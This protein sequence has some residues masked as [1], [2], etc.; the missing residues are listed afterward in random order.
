MNKKQKVEIGTFQLRIRQR[1]VDALHEE[2]DDVE[3]QLNGNA[4]I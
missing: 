3:K 4:T 2:E 1:Q